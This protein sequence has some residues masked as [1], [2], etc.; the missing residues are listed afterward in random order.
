MEIVIILLLFVFVGIHFVYTIKEIRRL[1]AGFYAVCA[2]LSLTIL[3]LKS[4]NFPLIDPA[5]QLTE[6]LE[7]LLPQ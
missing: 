7:H 2:I 4:L 3:I 5:M 6:M 1:E